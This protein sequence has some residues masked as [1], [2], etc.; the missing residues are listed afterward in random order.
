ML[1]GECN[2][3]LEESFVVLCW[4]GMA[5]NSGEFGLDVYCEVLENSNTW[6]LLIRIWKVDL[7]LI[8]PILPH[9]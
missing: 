6:K 9:P 7:K 8:V 1:Y 3:V 4:M 5:V 2:G